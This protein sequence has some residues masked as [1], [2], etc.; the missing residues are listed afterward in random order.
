MATLAALHPP[1][2]AEA[3][4][5]VELLLPRAEVDAEVEEVDMLPRRVDMPVLLDP[6]PPDP[7]EDTLLHPR[8]APM[9]EESKYPQSARN[10]A[11]R[12]CLYIKGHLLLGGGV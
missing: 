3:D 11:E 8:A 7:S 12:K 9:P 5:E 2:H 1:P 6:V 10:L 4:A